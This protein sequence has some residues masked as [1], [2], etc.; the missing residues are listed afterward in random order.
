M[1]TGKVASGQLDGRCPGLGGPACG[2]ATVMPVS[3]GQARRAR[4]RRR[5]RAEISNNDAPP[6][7]STPHGPATGALGTSVRVNVNVPIG[8]RC[9]RAMP[10]E[11]RSGPGATYPGSARCRSCRRPCPR[12]TAT[13][14]DRLLADPVVVLEH[15]QPCHAHEPVRAGRD[16]RHEGHERE[17]AMDGERD[18]GRSGGGADASA[19]D[20]RG[21]GSG[22][23]RGR[24]FIR[25]RR[26]GA[27]LR[28]I[29]DALARDL[30]R[31]PEGDQGAVGSPDER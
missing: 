25:E 24:H 22:R 13:A 17:V 7:N 19:Q 28:H 15:R 27:E 6:I 31:A 2:S 16:H 23:D 26:R 29:L 9:T 18:A 10:C 1:G 11:G 30:A 12:R 14:R 20:D 21:G 4:S 5:A 8:T 3:L